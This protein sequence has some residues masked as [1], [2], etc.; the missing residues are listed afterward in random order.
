MV[1]TNHPRDL[2]G[3]VEQDFIIAVPEDRSTIVCDHM[4]IG[5]IRLSRPIRA[6]LRGLS[7]FSVNNLSRSVGMEVGVEHVKQVMYGVEPVV[8]T[9]ILSMSRMMNRTRPMVRD[10][11]HAVDPRIVLVEH[12][13]II[14][15]NPVINGAIKMIDQVCHSEPIGHSVHLFVQAN[16]VVLNRINRHLVGHGERIRA[17]PIEI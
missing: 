9:T 16:P 1:E 15:P 10:G 5:K 14:G 13:W 3:R 4:M 7:P 6:S 11:I 12:R 2:H 17:C 8:M